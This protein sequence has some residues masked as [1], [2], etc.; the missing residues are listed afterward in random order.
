MLINAEKL[1]YFTMPSWVMKLEASPIG[2]GISTFS[3]EFGIGGREDMAWEKME[4]RLSS[5][6]LDLASSPTGEDSVISVD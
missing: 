1:A 5:C 6:P 3:G 4:R 2:A